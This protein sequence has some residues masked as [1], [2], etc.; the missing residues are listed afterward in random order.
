MISFADFLFADFKKKDGKT[1]KRPLFAQ[2]SYD[3]GPIPESAVWEGVLQRDSMWCYPKEGSAKMKMRDVVRNYDRYLSQ[4]NKLQEWILD[5]F[6]A[7]KMYDGFVAPFLEES[8][9]LEELV[10]IV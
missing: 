3:I 1:K 5:D 8:E 9:D 6:E 10:E 7:S 2:V 4:A